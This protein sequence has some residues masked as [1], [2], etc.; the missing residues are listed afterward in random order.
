[1]DSLTSASTSATLDRRRRG[2]VERQLLQLGVRPARCVRRRS[3]SDSRTWPPT[4]SARRRA[5]AG[6]RVIRARRR[7]PPS[8]ASRRPAGGTWNS[9]TRPPAAATASRRTPLAAG[10]A[11][12]ARDEVREAQRIARAAPDATRATRRS[13]A[14]PRPAGW[15]AVARRRP[16]RHRRAARWRGAARWRRACAPGAWRPGPNRPRR[17]R[18]RGSRATSP[19]ARPATTGS[20]PFARGPV[21]AEG[22]LAPEVGEWSRVGHAGGG[23]PPSMAPTPAVVAHGIASAQLPRTARLPLASAEPARPRRPPSSSARR[24][25]RIRRAAASRACHRRLQAVG[26]LGMLAPPAPEAL[27]EG[28]DAL[29]GPLVRVADDAVLE[30]CTLRPTPRPPARRAA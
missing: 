11:G 29:R 23:R 8:Q 13:R 27:L 16:C 7:D 28:H 22:V 21:D 9:L 25:R 4:R 5:A 15:P 18:R 26:V 24:P 3:T 6:S 14:P 30:R 19:S 17:R 1:M 12:A 20:R 2:S 10:T